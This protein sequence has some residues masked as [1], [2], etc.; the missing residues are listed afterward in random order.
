VSG[1]VTPEALSNGIVTNRSYDGHSLCCRS[2]YGH[3]FTSLVAMMHH[4]NPAS[5][6][7]KPVLETIDRTLQWLG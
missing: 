5:N 4:A 6:V 2:A 3:H 7:W 1:Q